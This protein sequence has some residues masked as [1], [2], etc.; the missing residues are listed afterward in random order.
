MRQCNLGDFWTLGFEKGGWGAVPEAEQSSHVGKATAAVADWRV[1]EAFD[2]RQVFSGDDV[3][4]DPVLRA[5]FT[6]NGLRHA[7][8]SKIHADAEFASVIFVARDAARPVEAD[9]FR[10][11]KALLPHV[12]QAMR[13]HRA[14]SRAGAAAQSL[15]A[16]LDCLD[17]GVAL[18]DRDLRIA[19]SNPALERMLEDRRGLTRRLGR[20]LL[21]APPAQRALETGARRLTDPRGGWQGTSIKVPDLSGD[22]CYTLTLCPGLGDATSALAPRSRIIVFASD[23]HRALCDPPSDRLEREFALTPA[24]A[25]VAALAARTL[26]PLEIAKALG[27]SENTIKSHLR[28]IYDKLGVRN[29]AELVRILLT[30]TR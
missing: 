27:L 28:S 1:L 3:E 5:F 8:L 12:G 18:V 24:E 13:T 9:E 30:R 4:R 14:L 23:E 19:Y 7:V 11:F 22:L 26:R 16:A 17:R 6:E 25:R 20:L 10:H 21:S 2:R 15:R 29:Q